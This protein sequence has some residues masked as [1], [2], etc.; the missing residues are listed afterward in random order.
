MNENRKNLIWSIF[1][2]VMYMII[3]WNLIPFVYGIVD[4][5]SMMEML[6]GQYLGTP[7]VH[8]FFIG[9][10]YA[11]IVAGLYRIIPNVDWYALCYLILQGACMG[12]M[13]YRLL[14][15]KNEI[16]AKL[17][18]AVLVFLWSMIF[19]IQT[20][21]QITFTTTA[22]VLGVTVIF[23]YMTM[24]E[25]K[26]YDL[27]I[28]FALC[29]LTVE[30]RFSV[31]CMVVPVCGIWW[32]FQVLEDKENWKKYIVVPILA[33]LAMLLYLIG[34]G[35][36]YGSEPWLD[37]NE[38]NN[39]RSLIYDYDDY[40]FPRYEDE[41]ELYNRLGI[42]SK[43]RAKNLYYYNYTADDEIDQDFFGEYYA[44]RRAQVKE[45]R[46]FVVR[47]IDSVKNY[48]KNTLSGKYEY[49]HLA[50]MIGYVILLGWYA[51]RRDWTKFLRAGCILGA[52]LVL[53]LYLIYRG[54][55]PERV[56]ISMNL[57]LIVPLLILWMEELE[58]VRWS[59]ACKKAGLGILVIGLFVISG[60]CVKEVRTENLGTYEDNERIERL[61]EYCMEHPENFYF[62]DVTSM[63]M[64][65]YNV[66]LWQQ[67]PY[68]MN[69]MSLGDWMSFSPVWE[70]KLNQHGITSVKNA[71]YGDEN[72]YLICS[73]ERGLEYLAGL[74]ENVTYEE[75]DKISGFKI[76][77]LEFL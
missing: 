22:A 57:M 46:S 10:W 1:V 17:W 42:E 62:N 49:R 52:Q 8:G 38:Y 4:D 16:A 19:G 41:T 72:V 66:H 40:M 44:M 2:P 51:L 30:C 61:K 39:T 35:V 11:L 18:M 75:V 3:L 31:Y 28:L 6:S 55:M 26:K 5:R 48:I 58:K 32:L 68:K 34:L 70:E 36:G 33:V 76:Y 29:M 59:E 45:E 69:Y 37:Y 9:H 50:A 20:V 13:L 21:T 12:L 15:K 56:L 25:V 63:A 24:K 23:W 14:E 71:L 65:T 67:E 54:R 77:R 53:W 73:F 60:H 43:S 74:Y 27:V 64:S 47:L 7:D